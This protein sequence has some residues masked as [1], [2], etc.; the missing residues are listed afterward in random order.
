MSLLRLDRL[1][2]CILMSMGCISSPLV[3]AEDLNSDVA[4]LPTLHVE[5]TRTDT[6]Y[7]QTPAS[8]FRIEAPQVDSSSQVNL[9]EVVKGIPS[10]QIRNRENYAQDLQL[11]MRGFG[12][13]STFGVRGIRLY[14]DGIPATMPDGQ[15]Q[16]SNIDLSSLDHVEVLTGPFSSLYGNSSGGTILTST[17]E[18]QGKDSIELS[19]S[20]G[21]HDKSRAGLVLQGGAKGANEPSY[22]ISSSYF[23]TDG[24]REHS[25]AEKVL[26]NAKLSWNLDDGS[27]IN[28]VTNYVKI[29]AD[30][31]QGLTHDQWNANPK[32][33]V[34]FLKQFNVRKDIEQTQTGVTWSKP[35]N[36]KNELYAMAYLGNRQVTQYQSIPKSTQ[37]ASINHAGGVIDFERN[38]YGADFR[39]TGKELLPNTTLSVGVALDAMDEDRKGFENFNLVNGQPSYGVKGNLRRDE[40]NTLWNIDPYLQ[41]SWQ[42]LPTW[43]LDTGVRY[44]NVHYK[45]EDNYLS[46]GDDS[47]KTDYD[48]VLPS[49]ALSWQILPELMAYVSY[50]KGFETPTFTEMAYRPDGQSGFNFDLTASTSDTYETGLKSQNQ[51]GD[52]TLAVFQTKTKDDIVSAGNSNGRSTFRNAD[53]TLREGVEFAWNKKLWRDLTATASYSY[54]DATFDADIPALGNIAQISSGNAI[55]GIA[56]N[57]AYASLAWQPS[58]GLYG[59][60]DVQY[61]DKVYVNDTNSDAAPSY[62]VTSANVGYAWVMGDWKVNS[63]ARVDNLFDKKYAGSVI[64]NDGNS[65]YFEPADGRNWSAGLRVIKQF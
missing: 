61:M 29:H 49:V 30:D 27:K 25:G 12:A 6:G 38:Y 20:G 54:L 41:A 65:R 13:R 1:H 2:Y 64:V 31:P 57:Q 47:G 43:R 56:K 14:V 40:D 24:Y 36:D 45:S 4:Q 51:L 32:Q 3:W 37:D 33:Q 60:V 26:N 63:F 50:A 52:F 42:F 55:P 5:A 19:Y 62:S 48:K 15:G 8:V 21:S 17:K 9:T 18:G 59:G 39:W 34:P 46:N 44:S 16:T 58:H 11:S 7:L 28:W 22:I 53:K 10:L 35:I 23:D